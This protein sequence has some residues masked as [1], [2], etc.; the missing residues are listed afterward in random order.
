M[1]PDCACIGTGYLCDESRISENG[2]L[3]GGQDANQ[4]G[5]SG[6]RGGHHG[7]SPPA[8]VRRQQ[9]RGGGILVPRGVAAHTPR[10]L[11][12]QV[13]SAIS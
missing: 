6:D 3:G 12:T 2:L 9:R 13:E 10:R 7:S 4:P 1:D 11:G 8:G 5:A